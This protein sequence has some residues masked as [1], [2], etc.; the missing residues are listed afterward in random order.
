[1]SRI[2]LLN[3]VHATNVVPT[4]LLAVAAP[5]TPAIFADMLPTIDMSWCGC[6]VGVLGAIRDVCLLLSMNP[7]ML[8]VCRQFSILVVRWW[9]GTDRPTCLKRRH[10]PGR[11]RQ[12]PHACQI[13]IKSSTAK[14]TG[15]HHRCDV[16]PLLPFFL[17]HGFVSCDLTSCKHTC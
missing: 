15:G 1:L 10:S 2:C 12:H 13:T 16:A 9:H 17:S 7:L 6:C 8:L 5:F 4:H 11:M 3:A 14:A